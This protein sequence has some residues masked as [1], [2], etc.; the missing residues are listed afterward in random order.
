[1]FS[2]K[3]LQNKRIDSLFNYFCF[4]KKLKLNKSTNEILGTKNTKKYEI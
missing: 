2:L 4:A 1:M 3:N